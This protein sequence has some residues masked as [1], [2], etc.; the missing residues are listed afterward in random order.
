MGEWKL[1]VSDSNSE[2]LYNLKTE[3]GEATNVIEE[4]PKIAEKLLNEIIKFERN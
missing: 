3:N 1:H 2:T 4:N